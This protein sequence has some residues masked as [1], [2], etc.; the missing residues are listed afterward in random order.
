MLFSLSYEA[1][2]LFVTFCRDLG[3]SSA[4]HLYTHLILITL[5]IPSLF[6]NG[7]IRSPLYS[8]GFLPLTS[9]NFGSASPIDLEC[10][11]LNV[12]LNG[13]PG[14]DGVMKNCNSRQT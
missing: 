14:K 2:D 12:L 9:V 4:K 11:H 13:G 3:P 8:M 10:V 5:V 7:L 1:S 6:S